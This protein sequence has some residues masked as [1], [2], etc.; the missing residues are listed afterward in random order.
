MYLLSMEVCER[1]EK[2]YDDSDGVDVYLCRC[3]ERAIVNEKSGLYK[4]RRCGDLADIAR[5]PSSWSSNAFI[6]EA[7]AMNVKPE[8]GLTPHIFAK[9]DAL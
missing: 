3:G 8:F 6:N 5:V 9:Q 7:I 2:F 4:C 1:N